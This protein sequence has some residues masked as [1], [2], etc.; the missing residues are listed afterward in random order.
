MRRLSSLSFVFPVIAFVVALFLAG[1]VL[2]AGPPILTKTDTQVTLL[3]DGRLDVK[4]RL[5]F[6][7]TESRD[8]ITTMGPFD[9]GHRMFEA[10]IEFEGQE[11]P[12]TM[13]SQ[14][15]G[16]YGVDFGL[17]TVPG[18]DYTLNVHYQ[19]PGAL[20]LTEVDEIPY[21]VF[22]WSPIEWNLPIGEQI[23]TIILPIELPAGVTEPEQVTDELV[24]G[25]AV[26]VDDTNVASFDRWVYFPTPDETTGKQW[27]SVYVSKEDMQPGTHFR[28]APFYPRPILHYSGRHRGPG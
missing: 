19:V 16:F 28:P 21:R 1:Q 13:D 27:L 5:T 26:I 14:G 3:G 15:G 12:V 7:E 6:L 23:V 2:A 18:V 8:R 10:F 25:S 20:D 9:P 22:D 4:Y 17:D 11:R 24:D